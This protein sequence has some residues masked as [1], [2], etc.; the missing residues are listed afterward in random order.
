MI[1][2]GQ[3]VGVDGKINSS[4]EIGTAGERKGS[5]RKNR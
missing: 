3:E 1:K 5:E 4:M 2:I